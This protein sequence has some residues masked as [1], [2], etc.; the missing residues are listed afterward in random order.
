MGFAASFSRLLLACYNFLVHVIRTWRRR[1][2]A[3]NLLYFLVHVIRAL[4]R[5][6]FAASL[7]N[8]S[9]TRNSYVEANGFRC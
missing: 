1:G 6:G 3:A 8:F 4:R 5:K 9:G 2:F 7:L